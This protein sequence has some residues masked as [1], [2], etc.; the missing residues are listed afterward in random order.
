[1]RENLPVYNEERVLKD[2]ERLITVTDKSGNIL[3]CNNEF[4]DV[5]GFTREELVGQPHNIV[6]HPD[7]PSEVY[8]VMWSFLKEGK[9]WMGIVKNRSKNGNFYWVNAYVTPIFTGDK[10]TGYESVRTKAR[11]SD[12]ERSKKLYHAIKNKK[13]TKPLIRFVPHHTFIVL[14]ALSSAALMH[15]GHYDIAERGLSAAVLIYALW[16]SRVRRKEILSIKSLLKG[17]FTHD[18]AI[19]SYTDNKG[20]MGDLEV[21]I[22]SSIAH[23]ETVITRIEDASENLAKETETS[24]SI[25]L[26]SRQDIE[27]QQSETLLVATAMNE[28]TAT[29]NEVAQHVNETAI[30]A[31]T[32]N[33]LVTNGLKISDTTMLAI[34]K[35][36]DTVSEMGNSVSAVHVQTD[37]IAKAAE[38]I[39]KIAEQTNLLALNAA[40]ES[41]RAGEQGRGFAVVAEEVRNLARRTQESTKEIYSIISELTASADSAVDVAN[42]GA[43]NA[44]EGVARVLENGEMLSGISNAVEKITQM[45]VQ[46]AAAIEQQAMVAE[47]IN[48]QVVNIS[49][50]AESSTSSAGKTDESMTHLRGISAELHELVVRFR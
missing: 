32:A 15:L 36:R 38:V 34:E 4:V 37:S 47:D 17:H 41:A 35:L 25:T 27:R 18:V 11:T 9:P 7:M 26:S 6:R 31:E 24:A 33:D 48:Q 19:Q 39:E 29:I 10:L 12:I 40:I 1:M 45:S 20:G 43:I 2:D 16:G 14:S 21:L 50:L 44:E 5:S 8:Q 42:E 49:D 22:L 46:M 3:S 28:M 13:R 23:L 30:S